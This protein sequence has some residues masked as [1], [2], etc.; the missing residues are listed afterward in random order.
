MA[1]S[2]SIVPVG[3]TKHREGLPYIAPVTVEYAEQFLP[4]AEELANEYKLA[5][6]RRFV[7][8]SD[9]WYLMTDR[10]LPD[11]DYYE[12][13]DLSENGVGQVPYFWNQWKFGMDEISPF[14]RTNI[15][16]LKDSK[17]KNIEVDPKKIGIKYKIQL[18]LLL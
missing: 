8:L 9:E 16:E 14:A 12:D 18:N 13:S 1:R 7:F 3:L 15:V 5:D 2:I 10:S 6:G 4:Y 17:I 11:I